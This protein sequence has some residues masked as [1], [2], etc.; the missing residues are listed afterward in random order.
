MSN[1]TPDPSVEQQI[2]D[3]PEAIQPVNKP[4]VTAHVLGIIT[5]ILGMWIL[6]SPQG[7][8]MIPVAFLP[9]VLAII[10]GHVGRRKAERI[11]VG[12][13]A[14][15]GGL[16]AGYLIIAVSIGTTLW[17][18]TLFENVFENARAIGA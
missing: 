1:P 13:G 5:V 6:L 3:Q 10:F 7:S 12:R 17:W 2:I 9:A 18:I 15:L 16:I 14:A 4:A 11:G 8:I